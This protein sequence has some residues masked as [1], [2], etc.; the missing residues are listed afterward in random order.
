MPNIKEIVDS[1][2][3]TIKELRES[4]RKGSEGQGTSEY[5]FAEKMAQRNQ[6]TGLGEGSDPEFPTTKK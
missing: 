4:Q 3:H 6:G 2:A 5:T 1:G